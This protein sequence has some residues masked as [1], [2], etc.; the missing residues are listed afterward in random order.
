MIQTK[1]FRFGFYNDDYEVYE[2]CE[3]L[4]FVRNFS[5]PKIICMARLLSDKEESAFNKDGQVICRRFFSKQEIGLYHVA[6][7]NQV[8]RQYALDLNDRTG[9]KRKLTL[10]FNPGGYIYSLMIRSNRMV[11]SVAKLLDADS[12]VCHFH[13]KLKERAGSKRNRVGGG[14]TGG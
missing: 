2:R 5:A 13:T 8:I 9:K 11:N 4:E 10:W 7:G 3:N 12:P 14:K 1:H 6:I